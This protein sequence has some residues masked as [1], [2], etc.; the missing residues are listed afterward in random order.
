MLNS[1]ENLLSGLAD[2]ILGLAQAALKQANMH[3]VFMDPGNEHW[4]L[5]AVLNAAHAGELFIKAA[6]AVEHPL[7]IFKDIHGLDDR[8]SIELDFK[9]LLEKGKTYGF[10]QLPQVLW[11]TTGIRVPDQICY[12]RIQKLRNSIQHFCSP[13][14]QDPSGAAIDFIYK[15]IDPIIYERFGLCAIE[16]HEDHYVGYDYIVGALLNRG[17]KFSL[18]ATFCIG[19]IDIEEEISYSGEGY[20]KWF[21]SELSRLGKSHLYNYHND[22]DT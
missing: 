21:A 6:V 10:D 9:T 8:R 16:F 18:P 12:D 19:E 13:D 3:A 14:D 15:I 11:T 22:S 5:M 1:H 7:L 20:K 17:V 4:P 2:R